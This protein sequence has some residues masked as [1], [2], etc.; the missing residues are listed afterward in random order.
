M[1][2]YSSFV[3]SMAFC[4]SLIKIRKSFYFSVS[5]LSILLLVG[6]SGFD[7]NGNPPPKVQATPTVV[8]TALSQLQWC[9]KPLVVFRDLGAASSNA[10]PVT[11]TPGAQATAT[12]TTVA[13]TPKTISD[14][15]QVKPA[16]GF[17]VFLPEK[18][19]QGTCLM[20]VSGTVHDPIFGGS[21]TI[22]YLLPDQSA[23]SLSEAPVRAQNTAF[24]CSPSS[25]STGVKGGAA[26]ATAAA[27]GAPVLL[28]T[29]VRDK[30]N[31][32]F[33]ASGSKER[34]EQFFQ[35]LKPDVEWLPA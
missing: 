30:T 14:W 19:P 33:S 20:S 32:V 21:F 34:L 26:T 9:G 23:V 1:F 2:V 16:L 25:T 11:E 35:A 8:Q 24:Q 15:N 12:G 28:C 4:I 3:R 31:I 10:T 17:T 29:G 13:G 7:L 5:L 18:L 27:K 6:C 22:G